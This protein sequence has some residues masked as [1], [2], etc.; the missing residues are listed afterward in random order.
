PRL[1][2]VTDVAEDD[3][4]G[5]RRGGGEG[6]A[7]LGVGGGAEGEGGEEDG[8]A[9]QR[10]AGL[11]VRHPPL[12]GLGVRA[13]GHRQQPPRQEESEHGSRSI[14]DTTGSRARRLPA[15]LESNDP[16]R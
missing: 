11:A 14:E 1:G 13:G 10:G 6:V 3:A 2:L 8:G 12:E 7:A 15:V 4:E 5:A 16:R 9:R